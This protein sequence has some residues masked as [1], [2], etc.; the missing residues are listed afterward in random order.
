M[1]HRQQPACAAAPVPGPLPVAQPAPYVTHADLGG[2]LR[3]G[4]IIPEAED[5][6]FH[7]DWER[8]VFA[9]TL[10]MGASGAWTLDMSRAAR[11][12]L[13]GYD[14]L[15]YYEVWF[16]ALQRLLLERGIVTTDEIA[17]GHALAP[18]VSGLRVLHEG[19]VDAALRRG[20]PT[21]RAPSA[22]ARFAVGERVVTRA[23]AVARHTRLPGYAR[24]RQG[25]IERVHGVH[26]LADAHARGLGEQPQWLYAVGFDGVE[27]WDGPGGPASVS[28]DLWESYLEAAAREP[29]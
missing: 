24:G 1:D 12:Q 16:E 6:R 19:D 27:L 3:P 13:P 14:R 15:S 21:E 7:A 25:I 23:D 9:L 20:S 17:R 18:P 8:V 4:S 2:T 10:A 29:A 28:L 26:V 5:E 11:E 22:P